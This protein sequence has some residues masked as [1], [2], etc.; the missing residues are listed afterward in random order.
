MGEADQAA[1]DYLGA[2]DWKAEAVAPN[3]H[4]IASGW[5][6]DGEV[7]EAAALEIRTV[8]GSERTT[9]LMEA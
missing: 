1:V 8:Q 5:D 3:Q 4:S 9:R 2:D 7:V 6:D